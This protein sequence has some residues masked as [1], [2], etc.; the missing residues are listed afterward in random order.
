MAA[1]KIVDFKDILADYNPNHNTTTNRLTRYEKAKILGMRMEQLARGAPPLVD[2]LPKPPPDMGGP[3]ALVRLIAEQELQE[4][5]LPYMVQRRLP[6]G[7]REF[8]RLC[9]MFIA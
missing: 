7:S 2:P 1:T 3:T 5:K 6:N 9:D 8:W 4:R